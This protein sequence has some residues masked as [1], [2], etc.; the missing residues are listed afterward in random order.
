M[1]HDAVLLGINF[2][3]SGGHNLPKEVFWDKK[4]TELLTMQW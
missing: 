3:L 1:M 4:A 2:M